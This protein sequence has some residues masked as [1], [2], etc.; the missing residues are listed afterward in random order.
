MLKQDFQMPESPV[1]CKDTVRMYVLMCNERSGLRKE[2]YMYQMH[3][4]DYSDVS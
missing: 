4:C 2:N 3:R 1:L